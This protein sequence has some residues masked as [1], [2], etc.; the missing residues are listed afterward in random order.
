MQI[1]FSVSYGLGALG[2]GSVGDSL[3]V[4][5]AAGEGFLIYGSDTANGVK[6]LSLGPVALPGSGY[7]TAGGLNGVPTTVQ[8]GEGLTVQAAGSSMRLFSYANPQAAMTVQVFGPDGSLGAPVT[9]SSSQGPLVGVTT[10][11]I[12]GGP[13][14]DLA[15]LSFRNFN[16][17]KLYDLSAGGMLTYQGTVQD[18]AKTYL[19]DVSDT[20]ALT[21]AGADYLLTLSALEG[22]VTS[23]GR[24]GGTLGLVDSLG[25]IDGLPL[26][27]AAA[28]QALVM[29]GVTYAVIAATGS[30]ALTVVRVNAMGCLFATDTLYDDLTTRFARP[31]TLDVFTWAGRSFIVT[32]GSDA[33]VQVMELRPDGKLTPFATGVFETGAGLGSIT[34]LEV[35]VSG[36]QMQ[37]WAVDETNGK[38]S[39]FGMDLSG[40]GGTILAGGGTTTGT[41]LGEMIWGGSGAQVLQGAGGEDWIYDGSGSDTLTGGSGADVFLFAAD[42]AMDTISDFELH[43]DRIDLSDWGRIYSAAALT[44]TPTATGATLSWGSQ[45][46][47][48]QS[49][50]GQSLSA[51]SF[52]DTDFI[53]I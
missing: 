29:G 53:F 52:V 28:M 41:G 40:V 34:A 46:I 18:S 21:V 22:G 4:F 9:A 32:G 25:A 26:A 19:A 2:I 10:F 15:A 30:S 14:G 33:G 7:L 31:E 51:A 16:G 47:T 48:V 6:L 13:A 50:T 20:L 37:A 12:L 3:S 27:G 24:I 23:F 17:L 36:G 38:V 49:A 42:G 43:K 44:I 45:Q 5:S 8:P 1:T 35:A 39:Q 11:E